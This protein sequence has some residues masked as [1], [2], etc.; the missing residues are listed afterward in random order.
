MSVQLLK[1]LPV[2]PAAHE[3]VSALHSALRTKLQFRVNA[4]G[5]SVVEQESTEQIGQLELMQ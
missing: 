5:K 3:Q 2:Y 1:P 4:A